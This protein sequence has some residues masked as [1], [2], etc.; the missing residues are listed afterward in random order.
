[1]K[2]NNIPIHLLFSEE[3]NLCSLEKSFTGCSAGDGSALFRLILRLNDRA[4]VSS[5]DFS[6]ME[7]AIIDL[8]KRLPNDTLIEC[9][10]SCRH[11][12]FCPYGDN[13]D[14]IHCL[15]GYALASKDD[16]ANIMAAKGYKRQTRALLH[17][18]EQYHR[19]TANDDLYVYNGWLVDQIKT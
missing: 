2:L 19:I 5:R 7:C 16:V 15:I 3:R 6:N 14:E 4:Y 18:C 9:C 10:Q 13:E 8:Q 17:R 1:M 12:N 11:G